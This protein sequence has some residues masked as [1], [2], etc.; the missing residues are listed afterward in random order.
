MR[1]AVLLFLALLAVGCGGGEHGPMMMTGPSGMMGGYG[2]GYG[3]EFM[4]VAPLGGS[5]GV[6][7]STSITL[8]FGVGMAGGMEQ[9]VDLH[10]GSIA[11]PVVPMGCTWSSDR[12]TLTCTPGSPLGPRTTYVFHVGAGMMTQAGQPIDYGRYGPGMGGQ[13]LMD[14]M[15][16]PTHAGGPWGMMGPGWHGSNGSYGMEFPFTTA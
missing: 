11:G 7:T 15:M 16:G 4:S 13:W 14:G 2:Y 6:P 12:T 8:R 5:T 10:V 3:A 1:N 9:Y